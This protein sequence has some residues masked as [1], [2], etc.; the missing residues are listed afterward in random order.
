MC[1]E[2]LHAI[3][4]SRSALNIRPSTKFRNASAD[5]EIEP[6]HD[7]PAAFLSPVTPVMSVITESKPHVHLG[8]SLLHMEHCSCARSSISRFV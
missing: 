6:S 7:R 3:L 2:A 1:P 4:V 8:Q 5:H